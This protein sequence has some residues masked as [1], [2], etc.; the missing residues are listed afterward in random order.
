[1]DFINAELPPDY[2]CLICLKEDP[3]GKSNSLVSNF[4]GVENE[5]SSE[6][7]STLQQA[8]FRDGKVESLLNVGINLN[9]FSIFPKTG[10]PYF[11]YTT[12]LANMDN[13]TDVQ[14]ALD[15]LNYVLE[16]RA[17]SFLLKAEQLLIVDQTRALHGREV[18]GAGQEDIAADQH[19]LV[20]HSFVSR[21]KLQ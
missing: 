4:V 14:I 18:V 12:N 6:T 9:P 19:R 2:I 3:L 20:L 13:S 8:V 5:L 15:D 10:D 17:K 11:H 21:L 7:L 16:V 1:M